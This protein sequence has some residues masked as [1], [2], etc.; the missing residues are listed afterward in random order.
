M[1]KGAALLPTNILLIEANYAETSA[2]TE[3]NVALDD[4]KEYKDVGVSD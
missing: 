3:T 2:A 1:Y 4:V